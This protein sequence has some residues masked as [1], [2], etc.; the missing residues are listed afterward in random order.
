MHTVILPQVFI[1][2]S[3]VFEKEKLES[4]FKGLHRITPS[5][6]DEQASFSRE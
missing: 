2:L 3:W 1:S 5:E 6:D 4:L